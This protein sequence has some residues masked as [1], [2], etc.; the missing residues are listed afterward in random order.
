MDDKKDKEMKKTLFP[1]D[2]PEYYWDGIIAE[3]DDSKINPPDNKNKGVLFKRENSDSNSVSLNKDDLYNYEYNPNA[4]NVNHSRFTTV[5]YCNTFDNQHMLMVQIKHELDMFSY[6]YPNS[7]YGVF[8][9]SISYDQKSGKIIN[10]VTYLECKTDKDKYT[11]DDYIYTCENDDP[12][13]AYNALFQHV[14]LD[15]GNYYNAVMDCKFEINSMNQKEKII[16]SIITV[17]KE[18]LINESIE[19]ISKNKETFE[20][21][22]EPDEVY[23]GILNEFTI[24]DNNI[25]V[26]KIDSRY[27]EEGYNYYK[28]Q[29]VYEYD[30]DTYKPQPTGRMVYDKLYRQDEAEKEIEMELKRYK[31]FNIK[32]IIANNHYIQGFTHVTYRMDEYNSKDKED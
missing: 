7:I 26:V 6:K 11:S 1:Y 18:S 9:V 22:Y 2:V 28:T 20:R 13:D 21:I 8:N 17:S 23:Q 27:I 31:D 5:T 25:R 14:I 3:H 32:V 30:K 16:F 10:K 19:E 15:S 29:V 24:Y 4:I 12:Y